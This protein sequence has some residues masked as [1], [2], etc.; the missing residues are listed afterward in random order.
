MSFSPDSARWMHPMWTGSQT[1]VL[2]AAV[3]DM[4]AFAIFCA[5]ATCNLD[6]FCTVSVLSVFAFDNVSSISWTSCLARWISPAFT[7]TSKTQ[8]KAMAS[9]LTSTQSHTLLATMLQS[10]TKC[11][12]GSPV[13]WESTIKYAPLFLLFLHLTSSNHPLVSTSYFKYVQICSNGVLDWDCCPRPGWASCIVLTKALDDT[14]CTVDITVTTSSLDEGHVVPERNQVPFNATK[15]HEARRGKKKKMVTPRIPW[16][17]SGPITHLP[18]EPHLWYIS[19][20][21]LSTAS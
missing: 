8:L 12:N 2:S 4:Y 11:Y 18:P 13:G 3:L 14:K 15:C 5:P 6:R 17:I 19:K 1:E 20:D 10:A 7:Q 16:H 9:G 21:A